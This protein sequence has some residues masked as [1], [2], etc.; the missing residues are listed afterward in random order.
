[1]MELMG[2]PNKWVAWI[3]ECLKSAWI[4]VLVNGSSTDYFQMQKGVRQGDPLSPFLFIIAWLRA[5]IG[6]S[7]KLKGVAFSEVWKWV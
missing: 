7:R 3:D 6:C 4:S 1:M 2:F 5:S